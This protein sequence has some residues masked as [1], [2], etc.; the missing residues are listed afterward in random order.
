M[1][2]SA[3]SL[4]NRRGDNT[5]YKEK[6]INLQNLRL[7]N[8]EALTIAAD[9]RRKIVD[10]ANQVQGKIERMIQDINSI[11]LTQAGSE[12]ILTQEG[13]TVVP[14]GCTLQHNQQLLPDV[15]NVSVGI[16]YLKD[17]IEA[18]SRT[19]ESLV[20]EIDDLQLSI[21]QTSIIG[22]DNLTGV[23]RPLGLSGNTTTRVVEET[24]RHGARPTRASS[25]RID[26]VESPPTYAASG[27]LPIEVSTSG[28]YTP[29][30][31]N[32]GLS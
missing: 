15:D 9:E 26:P 19:V 32:L 7:A 1:S 16:H 24:A 31:S 17:I 23:A 20:Q 10:V 12:W 27:E 6:W 4:R 8:G 5:S 3:N 13:S 28:G 11:I 29:R 25:S 14:Y 21:E 30:F 22:L 18:Y 2:T